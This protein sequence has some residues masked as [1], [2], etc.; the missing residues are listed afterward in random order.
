MKKDLLSGR[1]LAC[2]K[3]HPVVVQLWF[4]LVL[5]LMASHHLK[6]VIILEVVRK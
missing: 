1:H 4:N 2:E 3:R 6:E 5:E